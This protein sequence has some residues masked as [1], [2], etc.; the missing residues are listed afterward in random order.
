MHRLAL[1]AFCVLVIVCPTSAQQ[2]RSGARPAAARAT[3]S[4]ILP[5]TRESIFIVIQGNT[6]SANNSP[7]PDSLVRLRDARYGRIVA[8]QVTDKSGIFSF[9]TADPGTYVVELVDKTQS[10]RAA[11][12]LLSVAAGETASAVVKLPFAAAPF[13]G[14]FGHTVQ[15]A[16]AILSA[17]AAS[18]VLVTNVAG[19][20]ASAR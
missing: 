2:N 7:L 4:G 17:A 11:S 16:V 12:E 20:D 5:G 19:V 14:V 15:Q 8:S 9:R 3:A 6:L 13:G 1:V 10:V 18:G